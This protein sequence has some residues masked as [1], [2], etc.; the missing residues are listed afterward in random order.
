MKKAVKEGNYVKHKTIT[1]MN[2][3]KPFHVI[4]V[5]NGKAYCEYAGKD[6]IINFY[7]FD[8]EQLIIVQNISNNL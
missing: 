5:E 8:V 2:R 4:R 3:G 7:E 6:D 1:W